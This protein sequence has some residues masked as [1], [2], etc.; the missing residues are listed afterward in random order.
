MVRQ[1]WLC[2]GRDG[3][4]EYHSLVGEQRCP[5]AMLKGGEGGVAQRKAVDAQIIDRDEG[6]KVERA[7][8]VG[9]QAPEAGPV[10]R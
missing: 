3:I 5:S 9:E 6:R 4:V 2:K 1:T 7:N 8:E 10:P